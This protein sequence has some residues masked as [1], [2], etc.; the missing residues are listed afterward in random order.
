MQLVNKIPRVSIIRKPVVSKSRR[1]ELNPQ[2][3]HYEC[4]ALPIEL[5]W[6]EIRGILATQVVEDQQISNKP[7]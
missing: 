3:P 6:L 7:V 2:P 1:R 5:R 4:G